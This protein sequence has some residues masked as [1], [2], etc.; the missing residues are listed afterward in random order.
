MPIIQMGMGGVGRALVQQVLDQHTTLAARYGVHLSYIALLDSSGA[1][2][3]GDLLPPDVVASALAAKQAGQPLTA[4]DGGRQIGNWLD[5]LPDIR[6]MVVDVTAAPTTAAGLAQAA[7]AGHRVVL[8]NKRP[9]TDTL[10]VYNALTQRGATRYEATVGAG[11]P[12]I[13]TLRNLL[14]SGDTISRIEASMSGTLGYLCTALEEG[15]PLSAAVRTAR[16]NGWTEPDPRDDLSG[17]DVARK[18]LILARTCGLS[19]HMDDVPATALFP[20]ELADISIDAF[21]D[22]VG[23]LDSGM[24]A[25]VEQARSRGAVLRYAATIE[26]E[27]ASIA[28][29]E[30]PLSHPLAALRGT[31][32]L[33]AFTT[34]RYPEQPLVVRGAGA[35]VEVTAAGVLGDMIATAREM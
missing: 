3:T 7:A 8:A 21:M 6:C 16:S 9:V 23:E 15:T 2:H 31:D 25:Q 12:V 19:W 10:D 5:L 29:R 33:F 13:S 30:L 18:A 26:P 22:R 4:L 14:D 35:G 32:N 28:M 24:A 1:L 20:P 27:Q 11:L 17:A 34:A